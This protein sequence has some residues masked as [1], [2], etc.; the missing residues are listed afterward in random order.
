LPN[1][2]HIEVRHQPS[3]VD[4]NTKR[5]SKDRGAASS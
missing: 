2:P 3:K 5:V 1:D 4:D